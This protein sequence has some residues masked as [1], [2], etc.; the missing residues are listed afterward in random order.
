MDCPDYP[1]VQQLRQILEG[2]SQ[3]MNSVVGGD[4][5]HLG[6]DD[7]REKFE[8]R[9]DWLPVISVCTRFRHRSIHYSLDKSVF[10]VCFD[11]FTGYHVIKAEQGL[12]AIRHIWSFVEMDETLD[13][14]LNMKSARINGE[15]DEQASGISDSGSHRHPVIGVTGEL[16]AG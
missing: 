3:D 11:A 12:Q 5:F 6:W 7:N 14:L 16:L 10:P 1:E 13:F 4:V 8:I 2:I 9:L 15:K